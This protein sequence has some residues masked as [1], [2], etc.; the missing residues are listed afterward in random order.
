MRPSAAT[1][2]EI[3][4]CPILVSYTGDVFARR[5]KICG[6]LF[7]AITFCA[8]A[9]SAPLRIKK[10]L[11]HL[12][13]TKGRNS[14][15]PSLFERDAYQAYLRTHPRECA[16]IRFDVLWSGDR[17]DKNLRLRLE[18]RGG[19]NDKIRVEVLESAIR[20]T[21]WF[22]TWSSL[23]LRDEAYKNFGELVAWRA[24]LWEGDKQIA[25]QK[26]FLW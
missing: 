24:T 12:I 8:A 16:G 10:V 20:K 23:V 6:L 15:S 14:I 17:R 9:E 26:S 7:L 4:C 2:I 21:G 18:T 5:I 11:P 22:N 3:H 19:Q 13:D 25:E 1:A